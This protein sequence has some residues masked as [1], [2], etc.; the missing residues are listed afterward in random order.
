MFDRVLNTPL[1]HLR[2]WCHWADTNLSIVY[3]Y[4]CFT[5]QWNDDFIDEQ[6]YE[7]QFRVFNFFKRINDITQYFS[8]K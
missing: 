6:L 2:P 3:F 7:L 8:W 5:F 4:F 1:Q